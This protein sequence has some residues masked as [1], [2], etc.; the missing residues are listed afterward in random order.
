MI[1]IKIIQT[2]TH[3]SVDG[4]RLDRYE[5]GNQ[6]EVG[7]S[8]GALLLAE[9]W[10]EPVSEQEP[11]LLM[12]FSEADPFADPPYRYVDAP[13]N[14]VRE[15]YPPYLNDR[16]DVVLDFKRRRKPRIKA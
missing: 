16:P 4:V 5:L 11:A 14:L 13:R 15:H 6:Y 9:G 3:L 2:V 8:L 10:A 1:R 12:P 7:N